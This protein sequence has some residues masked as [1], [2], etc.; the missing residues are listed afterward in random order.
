[1][2]EYNISPVQG[3]VSVVLI[4]K[5]FDNSDFEPTDSEYI[6]VQKLTGQINVSEMDAEDK[7]KLIRGLPEDSEETKRLVRITTQ[8]INNIRDS[9]SDNVKERILEIINEA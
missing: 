6:D 9:S 5:F 4:E 2:Q 1:M 8:I 3:A 7:R